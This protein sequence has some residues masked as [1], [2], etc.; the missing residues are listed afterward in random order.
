MQI[1]DCLNVKG[2]FFLKQQ[3]I[4]QL[5]ALITA[6]F[7]LVAALAWNDAIKSLFAEGG[8]LYFLASWGI[9]AY[10]LFVTVLAVVL[11]IW[12]GGLAEKSKK[13]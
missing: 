1:I 8:A 4:N 9:W 12:I 3:V 7:G 10:A 11:T 5:A 13:E 2:G 6:A